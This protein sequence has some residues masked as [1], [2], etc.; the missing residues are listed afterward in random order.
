MTNLQSHLQAK[1]IFPGGVNSPV[2]AFKRVGGTPLTF[3][4]GKGPW[5]F[6]LEGTGY[7]D[8]NLAWGSL[9][10]G[11]SHRMVRKAVIKQVKKASSFGAPTLLEN[12]LGA[13]VKDLVPSVELLRFVSSGTEAVMS[14]VRLARCASKRDLL[15]KFDGCYHGHSDSLL[16]AA[17][18]GLAEASKPDSDG[19][20]QAQTALTVSLPYNDLARVETF[21]KDHGH[22]VAAI[23]VEPIAANMGLVLPKAG[24]LE[25]LRKLAT[26]Y[27]S[28]LIF[29]EVITGFRVNLGGA[30]RLYGIQPDLSTFGKI[31]GG[32]LPAAAFGGKREIMELLAPLGPV[33]QAGTLSGN[34]LAM[35]AGLATL[36]ELA[37]TKNQ[38]RIAEN[39]V[40]F[41]RELQRILQAKGISVPALGPMFA[42]FY[43]D[44]APLNWQEVEA[45]DHSKYG[46]FFHKA[47]EAGLYFSPS[48]FESHFISTAH[49]E[50]QLTAA[51][52]KLERMQQ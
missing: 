19:V 31:I 9:I 42:L 25:G 37:K 50:R 23:L 34:P 48:P 38:T 11:H 36:T 35:A 12:Q 4:H 10:L 51:L 32:G 29:D 49:T 17:G 44:Q 46:P 6:D 39:A 47:K 45:S 41:I 24:F 2:R 43:A 40:F 13:L 33:Y 21:F 8:F 7:L 26:S 15:V 20:P 1:E 18:S 28:I 3:S 27:G 5:V 22:Q 14:A 52:A 16:V 30:Q